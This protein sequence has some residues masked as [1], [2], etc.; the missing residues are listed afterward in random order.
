MNVVKCITFYNSWSTSVMVMMLKSF[1]V[2]TLEIFEDSRMSGTCG[3]WHAGIFLA[4]SYII[5]KNM[6]IPV[7]AVK[8]LH[9]SCCLGSWTDIIQHG[10]C[11]KTVLLKSVSACAILICY[12]KQSRT[13]WRWCKQM[14]KC[15]RVIVKKLLA[16]K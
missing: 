14:L 11:V 1:R 8:G 9:H 16:Y 15:I 4:T 12:K 10:Y 6:Y 3:M 5:L 13:P 2:K 7:S